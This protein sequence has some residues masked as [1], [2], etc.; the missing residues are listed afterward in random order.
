MT[1]SLKTILASVVLASGLTTAKQTLSSHATASYTPVAYHIGNQSPA[2]P[3][4]FQ[5]CQSAETFTLNASLP[6]LSLDYGAEVAG[7]P[8][9]D[10][11]SNTAGYAQIELKY[12]EPYEGLSLPYGD[13]PWYVSIYLISS[14]AHSDTAM[15]QAV[16]QW[17]HELVPDGD[18]QHHQPRTG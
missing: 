2:K 18:I 1:N 9:V 15:A 3:E 12:S 7:F 11:S 14:T 4:Q 5:H 16:R 8:Y 17:P 13:G 10:I 6:T